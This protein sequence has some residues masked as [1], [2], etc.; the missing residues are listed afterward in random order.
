M[1]QSVYTFERP[2]G[3][4]RPGDYVVRRCDSMCAEVADTP[5]GGLLF[6]DGVHEAYN[7]GDTA[8]LVARLGTGE[9]IGDAR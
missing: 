8:L 6:I 1:S 9:L 2:A 7:P 4:I 3:Q 5:A